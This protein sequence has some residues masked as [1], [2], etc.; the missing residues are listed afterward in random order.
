MRRDAAAKAGPAI[1]GGCILIAAALSALPLLAQAGQGLI[2]TVSQD[3]GSFLG[4]GQTGGAGQNVPGSAGSGTAGSSQGA[5]GSSSPITLSSV[6][7]NLSSRVLDALNAAQSDLSS[8]AGA[9]SPLGARLGHLQSQASASYQAADSL[10]NSLMG[11]MS[12][13]LGGASTVV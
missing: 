10:S 9:A 13:L 1:P 4:A 5:S 11:Q 12:G 7:Q 6:A 3:V 8:V 2:S